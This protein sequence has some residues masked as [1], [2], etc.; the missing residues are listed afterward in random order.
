MSESAI[1]KSAQQFPAKPWI[2]RP[3]VPDELFI[4]RE[5]HL[6][7]FYESALDTARGRSMSAVLMGRRSAALPI[8]SSLSKTQRTQT[9]LCLSIILSRIN[10]RDGSNSLK[11]I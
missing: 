4:D 11:N 9:R 7:Y 5:K 8:A 2:V 1:S 6:K 3:Q 10:P